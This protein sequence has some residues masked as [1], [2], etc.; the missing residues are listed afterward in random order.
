M[1][2]TFRNASFQSEAWSTHFFFTWK[3]YVC[4]FWSMPKPV[5]QLVVFG[6]RSIQS[7]SETEAHNHSFKTGKHIVKDIISERYRQ[8]ASTGAI[9]KYHDCK[10]YRDIFRY[11]QSKLSGD[12]APEADALEGTIIEVG[13]RVS[14]TYIRDKHQPE[15]VRWKT[16][17]CSELKNLEKLR[18]VLLMLPSLK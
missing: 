12:S 10:R 8:K 4:P 15:T 13:E 11:R 2:L 5:M 14:D 7:Y 16:K 6:V 3:H 18:H 17:S 9:W 1:N